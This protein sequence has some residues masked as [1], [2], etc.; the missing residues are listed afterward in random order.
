M[1]Y[2]SVD[3]IKEADFN[4][5]DLFVRPKACRVEANDQVTSV[6]PKVME[7]LVLLARAKGENVTRERMIEVCWDGR[8][9]SEDAITRTLS[10]ARKLGTLTD[11]PA[12]RIE[13]RPKVGV[14]LVQS[15]KT[16][17]VPLTSASSPHKPAEPLLIV[18]PFENLSSDPDLQFFSDGVAEEVLTRIIRGSKLKVV[19][20]T[21]SFQF[22]GLQKVGAAQSLNATHSIDGAVRRSGNKVRITAHLTEVATDAGLWADQFEGDLN[23]IFGLQDEIADGISQALFTKFTATGRNPI[24]PAIYDLY[25]RAK[26]LETNPARL[27]QG[28][29]SLERVTQQAPDFAD[30][31]GRL[32]TLRAFMRLNL[33]YRE[34]AIITTQL[35]HDIAHCHILDPDSPEANYASYW[36]TPPYGAIVEQ[37]RI[38]TRA[39]ARDNPGSDD[40]SIASFHFYNVG[41]HRCAH[42]NAC[43]AWSIDPSNWAASINYAI[44]LWAVQSGEACRD[45]LRQHVEV[46]PED[47]QA[48]AYLL[49]VASAIGDWDEI[50][51]LTDPKRLAH[52]PL[53]EHGGI[54][55]TAVTMRYP[56][57]EN[58]KL[59]FEMM[60]TR[61]RKI[62]KIDAIFLTFSSLIG[63][64]EAAYP[65]V[66][67]LPFGPIG[68]KG[69]ALGMMG[70]RTHLLFTP[71][72]KQGRDDP[73]F[74]KLCARLGLVD[75]WLAT[76]M[77][78]DC[79]DEV[80]YDFKATCHDARDTPQDR[81]DM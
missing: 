22:R 80:P 1:T 26:N 24:D 31:W 5:V 60:K 30:G 77:W 64:A 75:Y 53:R 74:V 14:R 45:A 48:T 19:G 46:W 2:V 32:A 67:S 58:Q 11:P 10:K 56:T 47:Q 16:Q 23:D 41:R 9:V 79:V 63:M 57:L 81:F 18:F 76:D 3:P 51:R 50:D 65:I 52:F 49:L 55:A 40:L 39:L 66:E 13:T 25:L 7:I 54:I 38:I 8:A 37:D 44:S 33:P 21:S 34:R 42:E 70:F 62:G 43:I 68:G 28:I 72:N 36:L 69:D 29:V 71:A 35:R 27:Q 12:F 15:D 73:R 20:P 4:I 17:L 78:P 59:L 6:E 61:V